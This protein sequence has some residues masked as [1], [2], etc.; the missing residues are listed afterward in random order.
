MEYVHSGMVVGFCSMPVVKP[1]GG[2]NSKCTTPG[3]DPKCPS[4]ICAAVAGNSMVKGCLSPCTSS[5]DCGGNNC[6]LVGAPPALEGTSTS[7]VR[8]CEPN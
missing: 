1:M 2:G 3:F 4:G 6:S 7:T 5:A 8:F